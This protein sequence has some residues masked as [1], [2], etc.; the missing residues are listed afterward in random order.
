MSERHTRPWQAFGVMFLLA[1]AKAADAGS[2]RDA[3]SSKMTE[4]TETGRDADAD[5]IGDG[6]ADVL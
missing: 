5:R 2:V 4:D 3:E 1:T 6:D